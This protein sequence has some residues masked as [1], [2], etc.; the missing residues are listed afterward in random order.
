M[1][2]KGIQTVQ[3]SYVGKGEDFVKD[4][5]VDRGFKENHRLSLLR[6]EVG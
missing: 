3:F 6:K 2:K 1:K 5:L 4:C